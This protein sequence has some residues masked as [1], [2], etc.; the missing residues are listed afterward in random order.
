MIPKL[1]SCVVCGQRLQP[2]RFRAG[3]QFCNSH[4]CE[5]AFRHHLLSKLPCCGICGCPLKGIVQRFGA[6][7]LCGNQECLAL[8]AQVHAPTKT[9]CQV[10]GILLAPQLSDNLP[11]LCPSPFCQR[12]STTNTNIERTSEHLRD[13]ELRR[14]AIAALALE[15]SRQ[16]QPELHQPCSPT[17][18]VL[19]YLAPNLSPPSEERMRRVEALLLDMASKAHSIHMATTVSSESAQASVENGEPQGNATDTEQHNAKL[20][21]CLGSACGTCGGRCC[22]PGGDTGFLNVEKFGQMMREQFRAGA[23]EIVSEYMSRIPDETVV[24]SCIFHGRDGCVLN[25]EQRTITCNTYM[26][27]SLQCLRDDVNDGKSNFMLVASNLRNEDE[28]K[29]HRMNYLPLDL[30]TRKTT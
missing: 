14:Q 10:C 6:L 4:A 12:W 8:A 18:V 11:T 29:V 20:D 24:D 2:G 30:F 17:V 27:S 19:P 21:R 23:R 3:Y 5:A 15:Q 16:A 13:R 28:I 1:K 9:V 25:R 7:H 22:L 26:C